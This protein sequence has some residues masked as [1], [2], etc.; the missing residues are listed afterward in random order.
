MSEP[1]VTVIV[2]CYNV[3]DYIEECLDSVK[4]QGDVVAQTYCV[5]NNSTDTTMDRVR[6]WTARNPTVPVTWLEETKPG[7]GAARNKPLERVTTEWIQYLDADD[8]LLADK[9]ARQLADSQEETN[10]IYDS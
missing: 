1:Q 4:L 10:V 8:L 7:A 3:E 9:V 2:P 5:D 6:D